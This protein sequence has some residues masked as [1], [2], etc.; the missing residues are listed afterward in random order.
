[1]PSEADLRERLDRELRYR[2]LRE[3]AGREVVV[4][5]LETVVAAL[6]SLLAVAGIEAGERHDGSPLPMTI[7]KYGLIDIAF[8]APLSSLDHPDTRRGLEVVR[9]QGIEED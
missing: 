3:L 9:E 4:E 5:S 6:R 8:R 1:M 7:A 2:P